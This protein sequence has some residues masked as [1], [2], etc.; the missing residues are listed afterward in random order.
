MLVA[1]ARVAPPPRPAPVRC[2]IDMP[3]DSFLPAADSGAAQLVH[4]RPL[5]HIYNAEADLRKQGAAASGELLELRELL[6]AAGFRP[7]S[8][9]D[10]ALSSALNRGYL[11]RLS[12]AAQL[13]GHDPSLGAEFGVAP[14]DER[15]FGGRMVLLCRGYG[16]ETS[17]GRLLL[18]KV[19]FLQ[20]ALVQRAA[21]ALAMAILRVRARA[22]GAAEA[23]ALGARERTAAT[24]R[25]LGA[26]R[27]ADVLGA[28]ARTGSV[29]PS[30]R[31][32][33]PAPRA[34]TDGAGALEH[35]GRR[36]PLSRYG[37][38]LAAVSSEDLLAPF[39]AAEPNA[40]A[41]ALDV[42]APPD[43]AGSPSPPPAPAPSR[44]IRRVSISDVFAVR[45]G[46][47][48]SWPGRTLLSVL[49]SRTVLSEPTF[50][51]LVAIWRPLPGARRLGGAH[52]QIRPGRL[53]ARLARLALVVADHFELQQ[54]PRR[55]P[56]A[57]TPAR[58]SREHDGCP[59]ELRLFRDVPMANFAAVL[60][61]NR[62]VFRPADA[63]R[64][65]LVT[66]AS[67]LTL[68]VGQ[69]FSASGRAA[70]LSLWLLR[71]LFLY[72]N[73]IARYESVVSRFLTDR[74]AARGVGVLRYVRGEAAAQRALRASVLLSW[75]LAQPDMPR[76]SIRK[77]RSD[78]AQMVRSLLDC[79]HAVA[80]DTDSTA[81]ELA[82]L[83]LCRI[84]DD[85]VISV[86]QRAELPARLRA[87]WQSL[88]GVED[89]DD[90]PA[91]ARGADAQ[92]PARGE[93]RA[94]GQTHAAADEP[95]ADELALCAGPPWQAADDANAATWAAAWRARLLPSL[96]TSRTASGG[97]LS[98]VPP[99]ER[100][101]ALQRSN[102]LL[103]KLRLPRLRARQQQSSPQPELEHE[104]AAVQTP[105]P[106]PVPPPPPPP[107]EERS[108][109]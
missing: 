21:A 45:R 65:D 39:L 29:R 56:G 4:L 88:L 86:A 100:R 11:F 30:A 8:A 94:E 106:G 90:V 36:L 13:A 33:P 104:M 60:P 105:G 54:A 2:L 103:A 22:A 48:R 109:D 14:G 27:L 91:H 63:L 62:L 6:L 32:A 19:D 67:L 101:W 98:P 53:V 87:H 57:R 26:A 76:P 84:G 47:G 55:L 74:L 12:L 58:P 20:A 16:A 15:L 78:G 89:G 24:A 68:L 40:S 69:R 9:R 95:A 50:D 93:Q 37:A 52:A 31:P 23:L 25:S 77:L 5:Q 7:L 1:L 64:L 42:A 46:R 61:A 71:T 108:S 44:V 107:V 82:R 79:E 75:L 38:W 97:P 41:R 66:L 18:P 51:E 92:A 43:H 73:A 70:L 34:A 102:V 72:T 10:L 81:R 17:S 35:G 80:F 49:L 99:A 59:C 3:P 85:G 96:P 28:R 83:G